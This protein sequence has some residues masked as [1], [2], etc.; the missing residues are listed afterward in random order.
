[1]AA[2]DKTQLT[3]A[4]NLLNFALKTYAITSNIDTWIYLIN[5]VMTRFVNPETPLPI[6]ITP[7]INLAKAVIHLK[8]DDVITRA[9]ELLS[10]WANSTIVLLGDISKPKL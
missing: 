6:V 7:L 2:Q 4:I 1:M 9:A 8:N 3:K 5:E 10:F